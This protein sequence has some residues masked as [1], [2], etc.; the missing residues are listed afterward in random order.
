MKQ[1]ISTSIFSLLSLALTVSVNAGDIKAD[2]YVETGTGFRFPDGTVQT[3]AASAG[4]EDVI[5]VAQS[6]G[7][8]TGIQPA[9]D[10]VSSASSSSRKLIW[11]APGHYSGSIVMKPYVDVHGAGRDRTRIGG[12]G[13]GVS[14]VEMSENTEL[15]SLHV[16]CTGAADC[17]GIRAVDASSSVVVRDVDVYVSALGHADGAAIGIFASA[18][19]ITSSCKIEL[20]NVNVESY[21]AP[22]STGIHV[23]AGSQV[24]LRDCT[25]E[26][27]TITGDA[28]ESRG[29]DVFGTLT[30]HDS[31]IE[32]INGD[33]PIA[34]YV[35]DGSCTLH[36]TV[37]SSHSVRTD[38]VSRGLEIRSDSQVTVDQCSIELSLSDTQWGI[39]T[40]SNHAGMEIK[41]MH[42]KIMA[43][44]YT[45]VNSLAD[46]S[47]VF[48]YTHF[49]G[50]AVLGANNLCR[51]STDESYTI[52]DTACP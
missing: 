18:T 28:G 5:I 40:Q 34:V 48:L 49:D 22:A 25:V 27:I 31:R 35:E 52:Y 17:I 41:V 4:Y 46:S 45:V 42:S 14:T 7:D 37:I 39:L 30:A 8:F 43:N 33:D 16:S 36:D 23:S 21:S 6:G 10:S 11:V 19:T 32:A 26:V 3:S 13:N 51:Y 20:E 50:G 29:V 15:S 2:G 47:A 44:D 9:I 12:F 24:H 38:A 1:G